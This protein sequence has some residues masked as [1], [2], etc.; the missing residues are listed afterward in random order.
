MPSEG[1]LPHISG[2]VI[3]PRSDVAMALDTGWLL[4][5]GFNIFFMQAGFAM[6]E[7]GATRAKNTKNIILKKVLNPTLGLLVYWAVGYA[8]AFGHGPLSN[9]FIGFD[10]FFLYQDDM[11]HGGLLLRVVPFWLV[12]LRSELNLRRICI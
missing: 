11:T 6:L 4:L 12:A 2:G 1:T 7:A 3:G 8:F 9:A 5:T 10:N